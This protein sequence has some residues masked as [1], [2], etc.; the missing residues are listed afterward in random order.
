MVQLYWNASGLQNLTYDVFYSTTYK[1]TYAGDAGALQL[2]GLTNTIVSVAGL[3]PGVSYYWQVRARAASGS[4]VGYSTVESFF[5]YGVLSEP[6]PIFP[7]NG[8]STYTGEPYL[9][10]TSYS[11]STLIQY[12]VRYA[13][14]SSVDGNGVFGQREKR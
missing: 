1:S 12:K 11:Y 9:Y 10:W 7:L 4:I 5:T 13:T 2:T 14:N 6:V 8:S 3:T